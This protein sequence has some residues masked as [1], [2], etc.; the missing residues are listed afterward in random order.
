L[1]GS[2][3]GLMNHVGAKR[4]YERANNNIRIHAVN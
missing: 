2:W 4:E 1:S 3:C